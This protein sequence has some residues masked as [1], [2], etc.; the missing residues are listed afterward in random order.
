MFI[1]KNHALPLAI[2][3]TDDAKEGAI[4]GFGVKMTDLLSIQMGPCSNVIVLYICSISE[5]MNIYSPAC[6]INFMKIMT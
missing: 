5:I 6:H 3:Y 2:F 1:Q 4:A